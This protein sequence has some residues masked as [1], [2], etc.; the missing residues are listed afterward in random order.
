M[1][2]KGTKV[3]IHDG[4]WSLTIQDNKIVKKYGVDLK[5]EYEVVMNNC[6]MPVEK[7]MFY[8]YNNLLLREVNNEYFVFTHNSQ[9]SEVPVPCIL[10]GKV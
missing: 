5:S 4:S 8:K 9:V 1:I 3:R 7:N 10:C 6:M 2:F